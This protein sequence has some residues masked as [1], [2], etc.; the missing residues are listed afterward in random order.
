MNS[1]LTRK[2]I[3]AGFT[4]LAWRSLTV[5]AETGLA[6]HVR[7][8]AVRVRESGSRAPQIVESG[9]RFVARRDGLLEL[10][11]HTHAELHLEWPEDRLE[12]LSPG[13]EPIS[14]EPPAL[15]ARP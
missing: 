13:L 8:G 9:A 1:V 11:A 5:A 4:L 7:N 12:R 3:D 10:K 15:A 6:V 2:Q 14:M